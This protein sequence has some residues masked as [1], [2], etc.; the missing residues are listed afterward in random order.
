MGYICDLV[1][2]FLHNYLPL[3]TILCIRAIFGHYYSYTSNKLYLTTLKIY[4]C[5]LSFIIPLILHYFGNM[6]FGALWILLF[7]YFISIWITLIVENDCFIKYLASIKLADRTLEL[8]SNLESFRLYVI[9]FVM[10]LMR[11]CISLIALEHI[12]TSPLVYLM[13]TFI[14]ISM[15]FSQHIRISI[16]DILYERMLKLRNYFEGIFIR[17]PGDYT[18]MTT[19][20]KRG[21][22]AYKQLVDSVKLLDKLQAT[23]LVVLVVRFLNCILRLHEIILLQSDSERIHWRVYVYDT[24]SAGV[25]VSAPA[26]LIELIHMEVDHI[27]LILRIQY[28]KCNDLNLRAAISN[29]IRFL[30]LRPFKFYIWRVIP[31]DSSLPIKFIALLFTYSLIILQVNKIL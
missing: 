7:E 27:S 8:P 23:Y 20:L 11:T 17:P 4:C 25:L 12:F 29:G 24:I 2:N 19:D 1:L 26:V 18:N 3:N 31:V 9:F 15:D 5:V 30:K 28:S 16:F 13:Y 22:L 10:A 21:L 14:Y 6:K